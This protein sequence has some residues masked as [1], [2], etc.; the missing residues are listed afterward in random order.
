MVYI[1][2]LVFD[3]Y[4]S[5]VSN[6][7]IIVVLVAQIAQSCTKCNKP[8]M[9]VYTPSTIINHKSSVLRPFPGSLWEG[10][11]VYSTIY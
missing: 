10:Y 5:E 1:N 4:F 11:N 3:D 6:D 7:I 8:K 2:C 9:S